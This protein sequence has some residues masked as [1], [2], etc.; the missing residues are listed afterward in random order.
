MTYYLKCLFQ[1]DTDP[2][3]HA[4]LIRTLNRLDIQGNR[5]NISL[6]YNP[7]HDNGYKFRQLAKTLFKD[8][9][10]FTEPRSTLL[11]GV[12]GLFGY[13]IS[14]V[15]TISL[16]QMYL[17]HVTNSSTSNIAIKAVQSVC[18]ALMM[19]PIT[20]TSGEMLNAV[21]SKLSFPF[22]RKTG[23]HRVANLG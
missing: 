23:T 6:T 11:L 7:S 1:K 14:F 3:K 4:H 15:G 10:F 19:V 17:G 22:W 20:I 2:K 8:T 21:T 18:V 5:S 13:V 12:Y 9:R 16:L